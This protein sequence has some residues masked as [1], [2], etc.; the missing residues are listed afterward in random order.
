MAVI[1]RE[2]RWLN[3]KLIIGFGSKYTGLKGGI[4]KIGD[5][6]LLI[7]SD[8]FNNMSYSSHGLK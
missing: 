7:V 5:V 2:F 8:Y 3:P 4:N 1:L 6:D